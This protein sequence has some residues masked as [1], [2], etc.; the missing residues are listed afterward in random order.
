MGWWWNIFWDTGAR[1][2][3]PFHGIIKGN[4][5]EIPKEKSKNGYA[6]SMRITPSQADT[7]PKIQRIW[8]EKNMSGNHIY[9]YSKTFKKALRY[10]AINESKHFHDLRHSYA[11]RR[12]L[13]TNETIRR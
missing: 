5:L 8:R 4:Y 3:E 10:C 1:L 7:I 11:L 12:I 2:Q 6:W 9:S 13:E